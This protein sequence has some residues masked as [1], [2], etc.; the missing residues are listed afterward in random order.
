MFR[1]YVIIICN[2]YGTKVPKKMSLVQK[3]NVENNY[4]LKHTI[5]IT[6]TPMAYV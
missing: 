5:I 6:L 1:L 3:I 2:F 4:L